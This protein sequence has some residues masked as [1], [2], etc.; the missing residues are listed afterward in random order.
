MP[1]GVV[2]RWVAFMKAHGIRRVCCLIAQSQ[3]AYYLGD[4]L[5][6]YREAFGEA[7]VCWAPIPDYCLASPANLQKALRF[8]QDADEA[9]EP[10]V[11]HCAGG[12]GRT[13]H[14]LAAWLVVARGFSVEEALRA[15]KDT[16]RNPTEAVEAGNATMGELYALL[17]TFRTPGEVTTS[18]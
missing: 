15:V 8:L 18:S 5:S 3:L 10:T 7:C 14:V 4:P 2:S 9:G 6:V 13:G 11:V 12:R 17:E 1:L 16:G